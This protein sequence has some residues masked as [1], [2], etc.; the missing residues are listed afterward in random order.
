[1]IGF[2]IVDVWIRILYGC[3]IRQHLCQLTNL[4]RWINIEW[5]DG[6]DCLT[7][8]N[9]EFPD[10]VEFGS[11]NYVLFVAYRMLPLVSNIR[12]KQLFRFIGN[13]NLKSCF[14]AYI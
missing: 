13:V 9:V 11:N 6:L 10:C 12:K 2:M 3:G 14:F 8:V 4:D 7:A 1:M 5:F